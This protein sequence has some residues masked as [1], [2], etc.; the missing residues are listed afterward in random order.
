MLHLPILR[1]GRPYR[2]LDVSELR[3]VATGEPTVRVSQANRG[4]IARDMLAR[5]ANRARLQAVPV[6]EM[7]GLALVAVAVARSYRFGKRPDTRAG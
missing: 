4:L 7:L 1:A 5:A 6:A 3:H 2:S